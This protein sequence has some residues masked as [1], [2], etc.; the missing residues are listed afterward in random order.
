MLP[1]NTPAS[2][3]RGIWPE[4]EKRFSVAALVATLLQR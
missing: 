3:D 4:D 1:A 2:R